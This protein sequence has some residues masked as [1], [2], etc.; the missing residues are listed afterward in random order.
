MISYKSVDWL[1]TGFN[2]TVKM[3]PKCQISLVYFHYVMFVCAMSNFA[4]NYVAL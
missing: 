4:D 1:V 3:I 2:K